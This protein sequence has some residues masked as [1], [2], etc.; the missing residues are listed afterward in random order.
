MKN[1]IVEVRKFI[2][3]WKSKRILKKR[4]GSK[5]KYGVEIDLLLQKLIAVWLFSN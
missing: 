1:L 4:G 2:V 5:P 3:D